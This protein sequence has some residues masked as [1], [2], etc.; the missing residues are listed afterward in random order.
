MTF[1]KKQKTD[2]RFSDTM[3]SK[4]NKHF[5]GRTDVKQSVILLSG[6]IDDEKCTQ[7][8]GEIIQTNLAQ[9]EDRP[10]VI[11]F[12]L[13]SGGGDM[14]PAV[15][16]LA[17]LRSSKIPIR[18]FALGSVGSAAF[19]L[20]MAGHQRVCD[21]YCDLLSHQFSADRVSGTYNDLKVAHAQMDRYFEK[22]CRLYHDC[23]GLSIERIKRELLRH[24]D[25]WI[26]PEQALEYNA[27][28]L[29]E[30]ME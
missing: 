25:V 19:C 15:A 26:T 6:E 16:L 18:T 9:K 23:T 22:M 11:N 2:S 17:C 5:F 1:K 21:P 20:L 13:Q 10:D 8:I 24:E 3:F 29:I 4:A 28:D 7:A 14:D 30:T 27:I 12:I